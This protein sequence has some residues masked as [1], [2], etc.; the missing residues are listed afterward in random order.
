MGAQNL[1]VWNLVSLLVI[2]APVI[3]I[4][5]KLEMKMSRKLMV[6]IVRMVVQLTLIGLFLN[7]LFKYNNALLNMTYFI[8]MITVAA[9]SSLK[10][11]NLDIKRFIAPIMLSFLVSNVTVVLFFN[12]FVVGL[13]D[14]FNAQYLIPIGGMLMGNSLSGNVITLNQFYNNIKDTQ[15]EYFNLLALSGRRMD[16]LAPYFKKALRATMNPTMASIETIG[17]VSLPGMMTGQI[18]GG[19][20]PLTAIKYQMAIMVAIF[21]ARYFSSMMTMLLT[22]PKAFDD[23]DI[24]NL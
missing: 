16:A 19:S 10:S 24:L 13:E 20:V 7:Y 12:S 1:T 8:F 4:N 21:V 23:Y 22:V 9:V 18:L 17:L 3:F 6:A 5:I 14:V 15:K 2:L 11:C